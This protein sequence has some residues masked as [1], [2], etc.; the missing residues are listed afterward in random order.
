M[1]SFMEFLLLHS[2]LKKD[3]LSDFNKII[4]ED[5]IKNKMNFL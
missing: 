4:E 3:F 2:T 1:I 5:Y